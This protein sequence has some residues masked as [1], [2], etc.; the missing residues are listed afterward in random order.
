VYDAEVR[1][2]AVAAIRWS[3]G[4]SRSALRSRRDGARWFDPSDCPR[5]GPATRLPAPGPAYSC[6]PGQYLGDG[7]LSRGRGNVWSLR[8]A[9]ADAWPAVMAQCTEA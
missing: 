8:I 9:G 3:T 1:R 6:L 4:I 2:A 7:T 5:G